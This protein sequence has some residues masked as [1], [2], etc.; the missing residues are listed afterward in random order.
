MRPDLERYFDLI[1]DAEAGEI[2]S[3][4][5]LK[6]KYNLSDLSL[7]TIIKNTLTTHGY[8]SDEIDF[9]KARYKNVTGFYLSGNTIS[10]VLPLDTYWSFDGNPSSLPSNAVWNDQWLIVN[11]PWEDFK[12]LKDK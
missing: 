2:V 8:S 10:L 7:D 11:L 9:R 3:L 1:L 5:F 6:K 4:D 12:K